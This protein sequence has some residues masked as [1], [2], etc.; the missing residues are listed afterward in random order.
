V[1]EYC[2]FLNLDYNNSDILDAFMVFG[3]VPGYYRYLDRNISLTE[4]INNLF[5]KETS[6]FK[7]EYLMLFNSLFKTSPIYIKIMDLL[8]SKNSGLTRKEIVNTLRLSNGG[9][10]S[11]KLDELVLCSFVSKFSYFNNK[12]RDSVFRVI[13]SFIFFYSKIIKNADETIDYWLKNFDKPQIS[14]YKGY[15]YE[16]ICLNHTDQI[17]NALGI[18]GINSSVWYFRN[19]EAQIDLIIDRSDRSMNIC[20]IKYA[21]GSYAL[22]A[23]EV[24]KLKR[25]VSAFVTDTKTKKR[26]ILT[27]ITNNELLRN[28][29]FNTINKALTLDDLIK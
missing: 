7:N 10:T 5:F 20:E 3:G 22:G 18:N 19:K 14:T 2:N 6:P 28:S 29:Y 4:N 8:A 27:I 25:R 15:A 26:I 11:K 13:D 1:K 16:T 23:D 17:K 24:E 21:N 9:E 12:K